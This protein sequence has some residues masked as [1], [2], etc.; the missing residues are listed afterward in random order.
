MAWCQTVSS[1]DICMSSSS[2]CCGNQDMYD[3]DEHFWY[4]STMV[5][6]ES[7]L[8]TESKRRKDRYLEVCRSLRCVE[9]CSIS[10][11]ISNAL[12]YRVVPKSVNQS[13]FCL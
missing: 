4:E 13:L 12:L 2:S 8:S 3:G 1:F 5:I 6:V 7:V 10:V 9:Y 11:Y